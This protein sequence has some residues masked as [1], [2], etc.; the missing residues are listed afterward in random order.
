M[1]D[2]GEVLK[3]PTTGIA[4]LVFFSPAVHCSSSIPTIVDESVVYIADKM[5]DKKRVYSW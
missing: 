2:L 5:V 3:Y 1:P 4:F